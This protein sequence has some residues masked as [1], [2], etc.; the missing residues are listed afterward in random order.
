MEYKDIETV[1][2]SDQTAEALSIYSDGIM[3][4]QRIE[5]FLL[6]N[7][8][9]WGINPSQPDTAFLDMLREIVGFCIEGT[10][11]ELLPYDKPDEAI[12]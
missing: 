5:R 7:G 8:G 6:R 12:I 11:F 9:E 3:L 10:L 1:V 2:L 4:T